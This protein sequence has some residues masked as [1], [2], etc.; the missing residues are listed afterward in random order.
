MATAIVKLPK[1]TQTTD[2]TI[3]YSFDTLVVSGTTATTSVFATLTP[4]TITVSNV[5]VTAGTSGSSTL[6]T[7]TANGFLYIPLGAT[8]TLSTAG[9]ASLPTSSV[10]VSKPNNTTLIV[11]K[12]ATA[13]STSAGSSTILAT[14]SPATVALAKVQI[15]LN[16]TGTGNWVPVVKTSYYDGSVANA[17]A[18]ESNAT[19]TQTSTKSINMSA[20]LTKVGLAPV[21]N[22][23]LDVSA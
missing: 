8:I 13:D 22:S 23:T 9:G 15:N 14:I 10:V 12:V 7:T 5:T 2:V 1:Q 4:P 16:G 18:N 21:D 11:N 20:F 19:E 3:G 6:T 17:S